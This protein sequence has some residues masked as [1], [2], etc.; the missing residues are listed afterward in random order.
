[1]KT[2]ELYDTIEAEFGK[3]L[4][5]EKGM[6]RRSYYWRAVIKAPQ[7]FRV[8]RITEGS[9]G[10]PSAVKLAQSSIWEKRD[11]YLPLPTSEERFAAAVRGEISRL[12]STIPGRQ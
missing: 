1:M 9:N 5:C 10:F 2:T 6:D 8:V 12:E 7:S 11:V 4:K 3:D